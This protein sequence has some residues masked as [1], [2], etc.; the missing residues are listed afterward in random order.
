MIKVIIKPRRAGKTY[1]LAKWVKE[2]DGIMLCSSF[3]ESDEVRKTYR[4]KA[5]S[6]DDWYTEEA[7]FHKH[8]AID[9]L[10]SFS[11]PASLLHRLKYY[12]ATIV[13]SIDDQGFEIVKN[14]EG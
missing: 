11:N 10:L 7:R 1:D 9:N 2:N 13:C 5:Y 12:S 8:I 4:I 6:M 14:L 3:R